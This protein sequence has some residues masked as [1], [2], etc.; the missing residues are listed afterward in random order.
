MA[1][2]DVHQ[3]P[4]V[5]D[6]AVEER[7]EPGRQ[8]RLVNDAVQA[9]DRAD[10]LEVAL[11]S[12]AQARVHVADLEGRR[13]AVAGGIGDGD[14][15]DPVRDRDEVEVV[16][17][18]QFGRRR[19]AGQLERSA[20]ERP[21][22]KDRHLDPPGFLEG[23][24]VAVLP[25]LLVDRQAQD[26]ERRHQV[27]LGRRGV[28]RKRQDVLVVADR[29]RGEALRA[30]TALELRVDTRSRQVHHGHALVHDALDRRVV[31]RD[32]EARGDRRNVAEGA[33]QLV[34]AVATD[35]ESSAAHAE[36]FGELLDHGRGGLHDRRR[37]VGRLL[38][39]LDRFLDLA[40]E[41]LAG[42]PRCHGGGILSLRLP[43]ALRV[44]R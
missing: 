39:R 20:P 13:E 16:A 1:R 44:T 9:L 32:E 31:L 18:D 5:L 12:H 15:E 21:L 7:H 40:E 10:D 36:H 38:D 19:V 24:H 22:R 30:E 8:T 4:V 41:E 37:R 25:Q 26:A 14:A 34:A 29:D 43:R 11:D 27:V 28:D 6:L 33:D 17:S 35:V 42:R 3:V 2:V 23:R